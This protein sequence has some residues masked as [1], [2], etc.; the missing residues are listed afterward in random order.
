MSNSVDPDETSHLDL[1]SLQTPIIIVFGAARGLEKFQHSNM[2]NF[3]RKGAY[4]F[5]FEYTSIFNVEGNK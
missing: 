3:P 1:R 5:C 4:T 2:K